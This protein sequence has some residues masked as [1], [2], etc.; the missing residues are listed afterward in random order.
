MKFVNSKISRKLLILAVLS[1]SLFVFSSLNR[2][3]AIPCC[4]DHCINEFN[5]CTAYCYSHYANKPYRIPQCLDNCDEDYQNCLIA[6]E[7]CDHD[8]DCPVM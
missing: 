6:Q 7:P 4:G 3:A 8:P 1:G 2:V 5:A